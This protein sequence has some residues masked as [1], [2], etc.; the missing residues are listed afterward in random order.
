MIARIGLI[1]K[2]TLLQIIIDQSLVWKD[3]GKNYI[4]LF[5]NA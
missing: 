4:R 3:D 2:N 1:D 5:K